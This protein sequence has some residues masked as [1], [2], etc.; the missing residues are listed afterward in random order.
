MKPTSKA[1]KKT[2]LSLVSVALL[3]AASAAPMHGQSANDG[4]DPGANNLVSAFAVQTDGK[5]LVAGYFTTLGGGGTGNTARNRIGQLNP[6]GSLTTFNPGA[7]NSVLALA[8]QT[9]GKILFGGD[10]TGLGGGSGMSV[11]NHLGRLNADRSLDTNFNPGANN[12]VTALAVQG[13]GKILVAGDFTTLGGGTRNYIGRL[14][15]DGSLDTS[16]NPGANATVRALVVQPDGKIVVAGDFTTLGG[17]TRNHIGRLNKDG[18]LDTG[19]NPGANGSVS[20]LALQADG[21]IVVGGDFTGLGG[22][23]GAT[24]RNYIGRL[25]SNGTLD[26]SFNPGANSSVFALAVQGDGGILVGGNFTMLGGGGTGTIVRNYIGRLN[27]NGTLDSGFLPNANAFV[28]ALAVE[29]N[30]TILLGG[31]FTGLGIGLTPRNRIGRL[32]SN[33]LLDQTLDVAIGSG[34]IIYATAV[35]PDGQILIG[36]AFSSVG[37]DPRRN[38]ARLNSNGSGTGFNPGANAKVWSLVLQADG[39]ILVGGEFTA[40]GGGGTTTRN[41]IG[42][43]VPDGALDTAFNPNADDTVYCI[44]LQPD[45]KIVVVGAFTSMGGQTR[46]HIARLNPDG[47]LDTAFNPNANGEVY[48]VALQ[49]DG[50]ILVGGAF[51][52]IGGQL[53]NRIARLDPTTG[54]A[55]SIDPNANNY[56]TCLLEEPSGFILAGGAFTNIGGQPRNRIVRLNP[57]TGA[58]FEFFNPN[59]ANI[60]DTIALQADGRILVGGFFGSMGGLPRNNIARLYS[61][62]DTD[63]YDPGADG[64]VNCI[65]LQSDGKVLAGG[66]FNNIGGQPRSHFARLSNYTP[67]EQDLTVLRTTVIWR[68]EGSSP[69]FTRVTFESSSDGVNYTGL[70]NGTLQLDEEGWTWILSGLNLPTV[71]NIYIRA[72]GFYSG[73]YVNGS[74]SITESVRNA[75]ITLPPTPSQVVSRKVHGGVPRDIALP[76]TGSP[77]IECRTGGASDNHQV[78]LTFAVPVT[79]T[80]AAV[81]SGTGSVTS[82]SGS[83]TTVVTANLTGVTNAQKITITLFGLSDGTNTG[84]LGIPMGVLLG[85]TSGNGTVNSTDVSQIKSKSGQAVDATNFRADVT[86]SNS[87]NASDISLVKSKS[88]TALP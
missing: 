22:D 16:F 78:I 52:N 49:R 62:G 23:T 15:P 56:V 85:D 11:R 42:R 84:S 19:F 26:T 6:D 38:I 74:E 32:Q 39:K 3:L 14:N 65:A 5:I 46:N 58:A 24:T 27:L 47:T 40:L 77:G 37:T 69:Q 63:P 13:D 70:G 57:T 4:F 71:Q 72:R 30:G 18:T 25:N 82:A 35:Q 59:A 51:T 48:S 87:I 76:L 2:A 10:F 55:D 12:R 64:E 45:G 86:V 67:A 79:F 68:P 83:G 41:H 28:S 88:G 61:H 33:G 53:R 21:K 29:S 75:F 54:L 34:P 20:T 31:S 50:K 9:D 60:V 17:A 80:S 1:P 36:G 66:Q 43:L 81:T 8:V 7:N 44:A 73:G